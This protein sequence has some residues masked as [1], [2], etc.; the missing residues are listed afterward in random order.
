LYRVRLRLLTAR[1]AVLTERHRIAREIHDT[2]GQGFAG[3]SIQLEGVMETLRQSPEIAEKHLDQA[4]SLVR[5]S[6]EQARRSVLALH[7]EDL[8]DIDLAAALQRVAAD[9]TAGSTVRID[10]DVTGTRQHLSAETAWHLLQIGREAL[11]NAVRHAQATRI[12]IGIAYGDRSVELKV[13][14]DGRGFDGSVV[15]AGGGFGMVGMRERAQLIRAVLSVRSEA[16]HGTVVTVLVP[17][18]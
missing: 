4:R 5:R 18:R 2:L 1:V 17:T 11:S 15:E 12:R 3:V 7:P 16:K 8:D 14:D 10:M 13:T 9:V 6:M